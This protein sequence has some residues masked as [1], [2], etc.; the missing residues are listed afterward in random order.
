MQ[1]LEIMDPL[2][3]RFEIIAGQIFS[4][5]HSGQKLKKIMTWNVDPLLLIASYMSLVQHLWKQRW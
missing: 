2:L 3:D 5:V 1:T 4:N